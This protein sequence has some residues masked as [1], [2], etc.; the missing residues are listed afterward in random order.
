M[1]YQE[2]P[3][4]SCSLAGDGERAVDILGMAEQRDV[5]DLDP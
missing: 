1:T 3:Q 4:A 5:K 2:L